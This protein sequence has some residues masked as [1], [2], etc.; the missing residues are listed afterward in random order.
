MTSMA[1]KKNWVLLHALIVLFFMIA[2]SHIVPPNGSI[3]P[4]GMKILG[5]IIS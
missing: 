4:F 1:P 3:T 5:I 2:F